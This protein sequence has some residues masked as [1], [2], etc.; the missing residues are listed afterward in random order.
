M[1]M[2]RRL[3]GQSPEQ[4]AKDI[5]VS[6]NTIRRA[7][8]GFLPYENTQKVIARFFGMES[9]QIWKKTRV[10]YLRAERARQMKAAA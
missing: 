9:E 6:G 2:Q 5:G 4:L 10:D 7:E 1:L 3:R 8:L